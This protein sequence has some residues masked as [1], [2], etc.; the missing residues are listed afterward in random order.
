MTMCH[1]DLYFLDIIGRLEMLFLR[2]YEEYGIKIIESV[3][4]NK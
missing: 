3:N 1:Y 2:T 4:S